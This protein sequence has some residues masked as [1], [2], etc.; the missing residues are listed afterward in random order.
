M[1]DAAPPT[2]RNSLFA[3]AQNFPHY[4]ELA[5]AGD[6]QFAESLTSK[7]L[8][9]SKS[10]WAPAIT[11]GV[12]QAVTYFGI[13]WDAGTSAMVSSLLAWA[14]VIIVRYFTRA[15]IGGVLTATPKAETQP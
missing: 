10:V 11:W 14:V 3:A 1:A 7:S 15:P 5:K 13:G 4:L 6:P 2:V 9:G 8:I 12:T